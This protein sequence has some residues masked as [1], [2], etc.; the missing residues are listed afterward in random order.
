MTSTDPTKPKRNYHM[1]LSRAV[2]WKCDEC[3]EVGTLEELNKSDCPHVTPPCEYCGGCEESN[4][5]KPNCAGIRALLDSPAVYV[6]GTHKDSGPVV[7]VDGRGPGGER[8]HHGAVRPIGRNLWRCDECHQD[9]P[10]GSFLS[11]DCP[12]AP[13]GDA[14][15]KTLTHLEAAR[16]AAAIPETMSFGNRVA[17][18]LRSMGHLQSH[19]TLDDAEPYHAAMVG[20][21]LGE[22]GEESPDG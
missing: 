8:Y 7:E 13:P 20:R 9:G 1:S 3:N 6:A 11:K 10:V 5:C 16:H 19:Q 14:A 2:R 12:R 22:I 21:Y 4:E 15:V 18:G 17:A